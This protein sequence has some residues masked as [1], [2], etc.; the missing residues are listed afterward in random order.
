LAINFECFNNSIKLFHDGTLVRESSRS[1]EKFQEHGK[2]FIEMLDGTKAEDI[3]SNIHF[4]ISGLPDDFLPAI[5]VSLDN[6][7]NGLDVLLQLEITDLD[8]WNES[9]SYGSYVDHLDESI[10]GHSKPIKKYSTHEGTDL[11]HLASLGITFNLKE[12][13]VV[14]NI[15]EFAKKISVAQE[16]VHAKLLNYDPEDV[17]VKLFDFPERYSTVCTQYI[18]WFGELLKKTGLNASLST[19]DSSHGIML[20][21]KHQGGQELTEKIEQL[22]YGYLSLPYSEYMPSQLPVDPQDK[23]ELIMLKNQVDQFQFNLL[24]TKSMLELQSITNQ[25]LAKELSKNQDELLLLKAI[26][27]SK[28]EI[29]GGALAIEKFKFLGVT[30]NPKKMYELLK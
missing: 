29:F 11:P 26:Q 25:A 13:D 18:L 9:Y 24:Q 30:V 5:T 2:A 14:E 4:Y 27:N 12:G 10:E 16:E 1:S 7:E 21:I 8:L 6:S 17:L 22:L 20:S 23:M 15:L 19:E 28:L 3:P